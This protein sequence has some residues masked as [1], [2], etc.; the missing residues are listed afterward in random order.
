MIAS[1]ILA[2][3]LGKRMES[4]EKNKVVTP[5]M[6]K[7]MIIYGVELFKD[8]SYPIVVVVGAFYQSI[9]D[10]LKGY[11]VIYACQEERVGTGNAVKVGIEALFSY[12]PESVLVGHGDH[13]M[14]Y[15]KKTIENLI[16]M[17][18]DNHPAVTMITTEHAK[19]DELA[20]GRIIRNNNYE[21]IDSVEQKDAT[22]DQ[23]KITELNAAL[24]CFN[25]Q[26]LKDFVGRI[27]KSPVTGEYYLNSLIKMAVTDGRRVIGFKVPF[28]EVGI[29]V[30][31][32]SD[33]IKSQ[34]L[35]LK[36]T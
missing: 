13:M 4:K 1:I 6:G 23:R 36:K 30:N 15:S 11:D 20:W 12:S 24:Y 9:E 18:K 21:I 28:E 31:S 16:E 27:K 8:I 26:F 19:P 3:G 5:F 2:A 29:G 7:P 25:Y 33:L 14:F 22:V 34:E 17:H 35:F 10:S 32:P